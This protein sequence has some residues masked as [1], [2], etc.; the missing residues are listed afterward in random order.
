MA[1]QIKKSQPQR[2]RASVAF[3]LL[4]VFLLSIL[5]GSGKKSEV[6][7]QSAPIDTLTVS[8]S[9][10][11]QRTGLS[12]LVLPFF[13]HSLVLNGTN[14]SIAASINGSFGSDYNITYGQMVVSVFYQGSS[15]GG[16]TANFTGLGPI[17]FPTS[18][19][20]VPPGATIEDLDFSY[21]SYYTIQATTPSFSQSFHYS[22]TYNSGRVYD[23][24]I[25]SGNERYDLNF[26]R[27]CP[28]IRSFTATPST[29]APG[30]PVTL[31]W[32]VKSRVLNRIIRIMDV[33]H[34]VI[35][36]D[37]SNMVGQVTVYPSATSTYQVQFLD[38]AGNPVGC[39]ALAS[40][41]VQVGTGARY[42]WLVKRLPKE[43]VT[44]PPGSPPFY[45]EPDLGTAPPGS[46]NP[47]S[48]ARVPETG[49]FT[50]PSFGEALTLEP[51]L[52]TRKEKEA[53]M[54]FTDRTAIGGLASPDFE[55]ANGDY[56]YAFETL[57]PKAR[58][59][60]NRQVPGYSGPR[61]G[62]G[63]PENARVP[64]RNER[65]DAFEN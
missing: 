2:S 45:V 46:N 33:T 60:F 10:T 32:S 35:V 61:Q 5:V 6:L 18:T 57:Y 7:A 59:D 1:R 13:S 36:G 17:S 4:F 48:F 34:G 56:N 29:V 58:A 22:D 15:I 31:Q 23:G 37:F 54:R 16:A 39:S 3:L 12:L 25:I 44:Y 64:K 43:G 65:V 51:Y 20:S 27:A 14:V 9:G 53:L 28:Q 62:P 52:T 40:V 49:T 41:D 21:Q 50:A 30:D 63:I 19:F 11:Y 42:F 55:L 47:D 8:V 24:G 38:S 26:S